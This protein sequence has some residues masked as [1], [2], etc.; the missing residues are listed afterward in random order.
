VGTHELERARRAQR[1]VKRAAGLLRAATRELA[2]AVDPPDVLAELELEPDQ[3]LEPALELL[4]LG[5]A[6][7]PRARLALAI[8]R[9]APAASHHGAREGA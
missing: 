8:T 6:R 9:A 1:D 2:A 3:P 5:R 4:A 7:Y